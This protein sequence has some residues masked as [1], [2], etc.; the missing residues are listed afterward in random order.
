MYRLPTCLAAL[1]LAASVAGQTWVKYSDPQ[2][3]FSFSYPTAFGEPSRG[4]NDGFGDRV[5][6]VKFATFSWGSRNGRIVLG[7]EAALTRGFVLVDLQALGGLYDAI[8]LEVFPDPLR[9]RILASL[10]MLTPASFCSELSKERHADLQNPAI[11]SLTQPQMDA[12]ASVDAMRN[13][14]PR[15]IRCD[16]VGDRVT[17]HKETGFEAGRE[18][19]RQNVYGAIRFL[20]PP[21]SSFQ[22]VRATQEAPTPEMLTTIEAV[23]DSFRQSSDGPNPASKNPY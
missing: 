9:A 5:A 21:F 17:F 13:I 14:D 22:L 3:R 12:I 4:S 19:G 11:A 7:G 2:G 10:P 8:G 18:K 23:V 20:R 15:V 6:A 16:A 1:L